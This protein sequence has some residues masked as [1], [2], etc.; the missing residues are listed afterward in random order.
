MGHSQDSC[1]KVAKGTSQIIGVGGRRLEAAQDSAGHLL[2][3]GEQLH[4]VILYS[5]FIS[6][7]VS[8]PVTA[9]II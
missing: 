4:C 2:A 6:P 3:S 1:P 5:V 8:F 9:V 7:P